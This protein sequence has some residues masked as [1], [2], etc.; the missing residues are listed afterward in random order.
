QFPI[1]LVTTL[2]EIGTELDYIY[3]LPVDGIG[4]DFYR[5][6]L[7]DVLPTF[8]SDKFLIAGLL[9]TESALLE[10]K[11]GILAFKR[12]AE[13]WIA[14][15]KIYYSHSGPAELLPKEVMDAKVRHL[16]EVL[17]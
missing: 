16:K 6:C 5:N 7:A 10:E 9:D 1:A 14:K 11:E 15:D 12:H 8:P 4:I 2:Q 13:D 17:K 3:S